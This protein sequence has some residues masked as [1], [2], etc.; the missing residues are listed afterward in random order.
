MQEPGKSQQ[1]DHKKQYNIIPNFFD[2]TP[3]VYY[4]RA[5]FISSGSQQWLD[6][7]DMSD[8]MYVH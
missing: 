3:W 8:R 2:E 5:V 6:K 1:R 4:S 7:I